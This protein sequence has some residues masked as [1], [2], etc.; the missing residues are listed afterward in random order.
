MTDL[1]ALPDH[2]LGP[3]L[4]SA[5]TTLRAL[6]PDEVPGVLRP[7]LGFDRRGMNRGPARLQLRRALD[8]E[9]NFREQAFADFSERE[10]ARAVLADWHA[11]DALAVANAWALRL[12]LP[13]LASVLVAAAPDGAG[14]GLGVIVAVDAAQRRAH[15]D[16]TE[17]VRLTAR[18]IDL[19]E[20]LRRAEAARAKLEHERDEVA[21]QLR[22]ERRTRRDR[23]ER[24]ATDIARAELRVAELEAELASE[25]AR[26]STRKRPGNARPNALRRPKRSCSTRDARR[27]RRVTRARRRALWT[28]E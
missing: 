10:D 7:L 26:L 17:A 11:A 15:E 6:P 3:L 14:F 25:R 18:V 12:D 5:A 9:A 24:V 1:A 8:E 2:L 27:P 16:E 22:S 19:E 4:E 23:E 28:R 21:E 13:L 20:G